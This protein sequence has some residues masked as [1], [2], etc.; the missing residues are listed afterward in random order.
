MEVAAVLAAIVFAW[1]ISRIVVYPALGVP[2]NAPVVLRPILGFF[3]A[4]WLLRRAGGRW[5]AL[6][7]RL[8][9][10]WWRAAVAAIALYLAQ[11][12]LST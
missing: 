9:Q 4:W 2:G 6:G 5:S 1:A 8:P 12:A 11:V 3:A 7:L 10:P